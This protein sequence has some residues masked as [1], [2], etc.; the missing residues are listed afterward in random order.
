[1]TDLR[2]AVLDLA[3]REAELIRVL[4]RPAELGA[5]ISQYGAELQT[6]LIV[7]RHRVVVQNGNRGLG[8]LRRV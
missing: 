4:R 6:L 8:L 2:G 7:E 5:V 1:M 3:Q